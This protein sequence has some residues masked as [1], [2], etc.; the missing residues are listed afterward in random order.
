MAAE[1]REIGQ[2]LDAGFTS[3]LAHQLGALGVRI[4]MTGFPTPSPQQVRVIGLGALNTML[5]SSRG[6]RNFASWPPQKEKRSAKFATAGPTPL[7]TKRA[8]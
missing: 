5:M 1:M 4:N 6:L 8:Y 3:D 7:K 2:K